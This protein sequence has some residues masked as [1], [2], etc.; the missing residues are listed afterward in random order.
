MLPFV[1]P[2]DSPSGLSSKRLHSPPPKPP[3]VTGPTTLGCELRDSFTS[4]SESPAT[5]YP[6]RTKVVD[7]VLEVR[8]TSGPDGHTESH[9]KHDDQGPPVRGD[10]TSTRDVGVV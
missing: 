9:G 6:R 10:E 3:S 2:S 1:S 5:T 4:W 7:G 8:E